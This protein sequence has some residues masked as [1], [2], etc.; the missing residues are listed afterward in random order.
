MRHRLDPVPNPAPSCDQ[1]LDGLYTYCLSVLCDQRAALAALAETRELATANADR[2]TDPGLRRAWL[3]AVARYACVRRLAG[4]DGWSAGPAADPGTEPAGGPGA[5]ALPAALAW[6][7]AAGT[8]A[9]QRE[10]LELAVRHRLTPLEVAAVLGLEAVAAQ[11]LLAA[12]SA[13]AER[14]GQ[15]LRVLAAGRC[16]ELTRLGCAGAST[17]AGAAEDGW[18]LGPALRRELVGHLVD[19]PTCRGTA[20]QLADAGGAAGGGGASG[21]GGGPR[22]LSAPAAAQAGAVEVDSADVRGGEARHSATRSAL[23]VLST[24][25]ARS[26]RG[27]RSGAIRFDQRGFPRHRAPSLLER[28]R[29]GGDLH[30]RVVLVRQR[31]VTTGV[32]AAVLSAPLAALWI[33]HR[34]TAG[35]TGATAVSAVRVADGDPDPGG[36][37]DWAGP[38]DGGGEAAGPG[39]VAAA[40]IPAPAAAPGRGL[41]AVL[42]GA[43]G[44]SKAGTGLAASLVD[45]DPAEGARSGTGALGA[46]GAETFLPAVQGVAVPVPAPGAVP[47]DSPGLHSAPVPPPSAGAQL[48]VA[49]GAYG[50]RTVLTLTNSGDAPIDWHAVP[51]RDW[52]RLSRDAG[53]LAPGQRITV[54][55]TVDEQRAPTGQ[56]TAEIALPP[57]EAVVTLQGGP[58]SE[59]GTP[60]TPTPAPGASSS[61][62][63]PTVAPSASA[64]PSGVAS[65]SPSETSTPGSSASSAPSSSDSPTANPTSGPSA[66]ASPSVQPSSPPSATPTPAPATPSAAP[67]AASPSPVPTSTTSNPSSSSPAR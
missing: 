21:G 43:A 34:D 4:A 36:P 33:A 51:D 29:R 59:P 38:G 37:G 26:T 45:A 54:T 28:H 62:S 60:S 16:P 39:V 58:T 67:P 46:L 7:A 30:E 3:Y 63:A 49:A 13:E 2:L 35:A 50:N 5:A 40:P 17:G 11:R 57:S 22:L 19:C 6:P 8:T 47:L 56:W 61:S 44:A 64:N 42:P 52:L 25:S 12:G 32:L 41:G 9:E 24:R 66:P 20:E 53:A 65:P 10:A 27:A 48:T 15:A 23:G 31:A 18:V 14:T 55:V 1:L